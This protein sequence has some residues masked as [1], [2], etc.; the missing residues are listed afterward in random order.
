MNVNREALLNP[1]M[2]IHSAVEENHSQVVFSFGGG[3]W[4]GRIHWRI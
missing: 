1:E 3:G 4:V 2:N